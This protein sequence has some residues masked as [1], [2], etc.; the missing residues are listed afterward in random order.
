MVVLL[1]QQI[2]GLFDITAGVPVRILWHIVLATRNEAAKKE[3]AKSEEARS[4]ATLRSVQFRFAP[5][6]V[7]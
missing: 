2:L 5:T 6:H 3:E 4:K 1:P 7:I